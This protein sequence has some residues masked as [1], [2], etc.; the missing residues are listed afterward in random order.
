[1]TTE[2]TG[3]AAESPLSTVNA[4]VTPSTG[5]RREVRISGIGRAHSAFQV[6]AA[7]LGVDDARRAYE[8]RCKQL[9]KAHLRSKRSDLRADL[10][11]EL[12]AWFLVHQ[13]IAVIERFLT[14]PVAATS[15]Q[16]IGEMTFAVTSYLSSSR[17]GA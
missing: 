16:L 10:D 12:A 14:D 3:P 2:A 17:T 8:E 4:P 7:A 9:V 13:S 15:A 1:M 11:E 5:M 6:R